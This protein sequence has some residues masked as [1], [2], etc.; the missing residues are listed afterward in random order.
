MKSHF[1]K[2]RMPAETYLRLKNRAAEAG[3]PISTF[4]HALLEQENSTSTTAIQLIEIQ[5]QIQELAVLFVSSSNQ[6]KANTELNSRLYEVLLVVR[7]LALDRNAQILSRVS[8]QLKNLS[9]GDL[10]EQY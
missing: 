6:T 10:N 2:V 9:L 5:S 8:S 1:L 3:K 4:A 7:E